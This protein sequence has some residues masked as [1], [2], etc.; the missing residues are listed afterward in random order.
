MDQIFAI[1]TSGL[2][3]RFT[4]PDER[5]QAI[6][7][8]SQTTPN[9]PKT[10]YKKDFASMITPQPVTLASD[11]DGL[12]SGTLL[13]NIVQVPQTPF[14][15]IDLSNILEVPTSTSIEQPFEPK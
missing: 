3:P 5:P 11:E 13:R 10:T 6:K 4:T 14:K 9:S 15:K 12:G 2:S 7:T 1:K 8:E